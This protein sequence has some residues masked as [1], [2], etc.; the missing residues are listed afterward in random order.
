MTSHFKGFTNNDCEFYPC[1]KGVSR[2]FNCLFCYCPL[3]H[4][5]C[6]GPYTVF[7][8]KYGNQRKDCFSCSLPHEGIEQS[9]SFIQRWISVA[10][11]WDEG[12]QSQEKIRRNSLFVKKKFDEKDLLWADEAIKNQGN[13]S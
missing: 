6:P 10:P 4:L 12:E 5:E 3:L 11:K 13:I 1:H 7:K 8:D 9:W 2:S